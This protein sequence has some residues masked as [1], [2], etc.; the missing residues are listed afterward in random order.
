MHGMKGH[1]MGYGMDEIIDV[2]RSEASASG[3]T[4]KDG[5]RQRAIAMLEEAKGLMAQCGMDPKEGLAQVFEGAESEPMDESAEHEMAEGE[6]PE[7]QSDDKKALIVAMLKKK[8]AEMG[9]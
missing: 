3:S 5:M 2:E 1:K 9:A 4:N 7:D 8:N 6:A